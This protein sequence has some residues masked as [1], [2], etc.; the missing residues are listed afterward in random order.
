M[1]SINVGIFHDDE[2]SKDAAIAVT[3]LVASMITH[4]PVTS[5]SYVS[6]DWE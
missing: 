2:I 4:E 3:V 6:P 5:F 1:K